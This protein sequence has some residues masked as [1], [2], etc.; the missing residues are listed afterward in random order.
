MEE[1]GAEEK[2]HRIMQLV[3]NGMARA[4]VCSRTG[5]RVPGEVLS[6]TDVQKAYQVPL[7]TNAPK[8]ATGE[9]RMEFLAIKGTIIT[10]NMIPLFLIDSTLTLII[11]KSTDE[12]ELKFIKVL[13]SLR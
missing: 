7:V 1:G 10:Q 12:N 5:E 3:I 9:M 8:V 6:A 11:Q 13:M 4:R 2:C